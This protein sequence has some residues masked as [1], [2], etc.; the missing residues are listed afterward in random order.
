MREHAIRITFYIVNAQRRFSINGFSICHGSFFYS[1]QAERDR[2]A[3]KSIGNVHYWKPIYI[4]RQHSLRCIEHACMRLHKWMNYPTPQYEFVCTVISLNL[5]LPHQAQTVHRVRFM[6][7]I[8]MCSIYSIA[9]EWLGNGVKCL[10]QQSIIIDD[11]LWQWSKQKLLSI[12]A[13]LN[14]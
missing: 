2:F 10:Q 3:H 5:I 6:C 9:E 13:R 1:N 4:N 7:I 14:K 11:H 8:V 12:G